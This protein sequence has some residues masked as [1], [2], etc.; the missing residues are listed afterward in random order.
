MIKDRGGQELLHPSGKPLMFLIIRSDFSEKAL[1]R[2]SYQHCYS[3]QYVTA[4][5]VL[6][7]GETIFHPLHQ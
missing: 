5:K 7:I 2:F 1:G 6:S 4:W 3:V